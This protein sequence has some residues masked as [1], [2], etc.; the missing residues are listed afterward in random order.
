MYYF[1]KEAAPMKCFQIFI[2][3]VLLLVAVS[4]A[5]A[6]SYNALKDYAC[7]DMSGGVWLYEG[8]RAEDGAY[9][10]M[11]YDHAPLREVSRY[12]L[13][14]RFIPDSGQPFHPF[15]TKYPDYLMGSPA[16]VGKRY[17]AVLTW[18]APKNGKVSITGFARLMG[19]IRGEAEGKKVK[20]F[21][22][23]NGKELWK[24]DIKGGDTGKFK[25][26]TDVSAGDRVH[27]HIQNTGDASGNL[28]AFDMS[29]EAVKH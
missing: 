7:A 6:E 15:M 28:T 18:V 8:Y 10:Q 9:L 21:L 23:Q 19:N 20:A 11:V 5:R 22:V 14:A 13:D 17:D 25:V 1:F 12:G 26:G 4:G 16:T 29:V 27:L 3:S 2:C 24:S